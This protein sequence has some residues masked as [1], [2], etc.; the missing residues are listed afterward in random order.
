MQPQCALFGLFVL[1][2]ITSRLVLAFEPSLTK[3]PGP[4]LPRFSGWDRIRKVATG[5]SHQS[6]YNM[7]QVYG[8]VIRNGPNRVS[9]SDPSAI[10][11]IY[12][13]NSKFIKVCKIPGC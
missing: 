13:M 9:I 7:H 8:P 2:Q 1:Y 3:I 12:A 4:F 10:A 6:D 11:I 5:N